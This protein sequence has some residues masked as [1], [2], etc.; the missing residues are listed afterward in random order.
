MDTS[1]I[2]VTGAAGLIGHAVCRALT[3]MGQHCIAIDRDAAVIEGVNVQ[4]CDVTD[5]HGL[6]AI[7]RC[8]PISGIVHC[9]AYSGPMVMAD[10]PVQMINVN[11]MGTA[12]VLELAR[13]IGGVRVVFCSSTSAIGP[14]PTAMSAED[15]ALNPSSVYGASKAA[16]EQLVSAY[17]RQHGV[18]GVSLRISWVYGPRRTTSCAIRQM[19]VDAMAARPTRLPFGRN[20]PRQYIHVDDV[21]QAIVK[22]LGRRNLPQSAYFIP[23]GSWLTLSEIGGIVSR[24]MPHA[25][26]EIGE[27]VDPL[28][29]W[30]AQFDISA[31]RRDLGY[32]PS[33]A[34]EGGIRGYRDWLSTS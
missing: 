6:H 22:A 20:F 3:Q 30:Q 28:D 1:Q 4:A 31:A 11:L 10:K 16:S 13:V 21:V 15:I 7:A 29:D 26:I 17:R 32:T 34:L 27:G 5:I 18:D 2:L 25:D 9:G 8:A 19:L 12:N 33:M 14:T 23:G 24:I